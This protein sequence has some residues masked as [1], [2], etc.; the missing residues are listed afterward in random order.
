MTC[1]LTHALHLPGLSKI[2]ISVPGAP[3]LDSIR[4]SA[5]KQTRTSPGSV[6]VPSHLGRKFK[7]F[8]DVLQPTGSEA[9]RYRS[10]KTA[11]CLDAFNDPNID[12]GDLIYDDIFSG[13]DILA[14]STA[15]NLTADD[16]TV[17]F[18]ID[19][20]Q[21]YQN[22]KSD[23]WIAIWIINDFEPSLRYKKKHILPAVIIPGPNKPKNIDSFLFR[24]FYH[25]S[26]ETETVELPSTR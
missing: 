4:N 1:A 24:S 18:S 8:V 10:K 2:W 23:T 6:H 7:P 20:A 3:S 21:L 17:T 9:L 26:M 25:L 22:K 19:G 11:Q 5:R 14:L 16:I 15:L 12:L 13:E